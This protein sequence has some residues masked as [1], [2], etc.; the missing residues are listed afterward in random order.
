[1]QHRDSTQKGLE[2]LKRRA[3][4]L[5]AAV[6]LL[7]ALMAGA[8]MLLTRKGPAAGPITLPEANRPSYTLHLRTTDDGRTLTVSEEIRWTNQESG[9]IDDLCLRFDA[10]AYVQESTS[11]AAAENLAEAAYPDGFEAASIA[12]EGCWVN[13]VLTDARFDTD[14]PFLLRIKSPLEPG[15]TAEITLNLRL[16]VPE[17]ASLFG[18]TGDTIRLIQALPAVAARTDKGWD[19]SPMSPYAEPQDMDL[20]DV[21]ITADLPEG[22]QLITGADTGSNVIA[23]LI[24]TGER[25]KASARV[26]GLTVTAWAETDQ[27]SRALL[28][29][30]RKILPVYMRLYGQLPLQELTLMDLALTDTGAAAPGLVLVDDSLTGADL[31]HRLAYWLAG[32]WFGWAL[33]ADRYAESWILCSL[34][35]RAALR[36]IRETAG[37]DAEADLRT[38]WVELPMRENL[39]AAVTPGTAADGFPDLYTFRAVMDGRGTAFLYALDTWMDGRLDTL[40]T[41]LFRERAFTRIGRKTLADGIMKATSRDIGPLMLDWL[42][43]YIQEKP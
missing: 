21:R 41:E 4:E 30:A 39:H 18:K 14:R 9:R 23:A 24:V 22:W 34:R 25:S 33:R 43:T 40:I 42:D 8:W 3:A 19:V 6:A 29:A 37:A 35:Q 36:Y 20:S 12:L 26:N 11:P 1:M 17:C 10:A 15:E 32:Q 38:L 27:R 5:L 31:E 28:D 2:G 7:A 16:G 13:G